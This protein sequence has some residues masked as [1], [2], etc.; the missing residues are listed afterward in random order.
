M[1]IQAMA[2][3]AACCAVAPIALVMLLRL[4]PRGRMGGP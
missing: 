4:A 3:L 2:V 1:A